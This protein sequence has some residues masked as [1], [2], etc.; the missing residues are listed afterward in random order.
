MN[1]ETIKNILQNKPINQNDFISFITD[2]IEDNGKKVTPE[3]LQGVI[4]AIQH[5][6]FN[7][8]YAAEQTALKLG[9][10]ITKVFDKNNN[11]IKVIIVE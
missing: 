11:I 9:M 3:Q 7:L 6:L 1:K 2:Y 8:H 10:K 4:A 5:N